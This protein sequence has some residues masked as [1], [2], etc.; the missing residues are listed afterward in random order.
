MLEC[1]DHVVAGRQG[2]FRVFRLAQQ[3]HQS[4]RVLTR[5]EPAVLF[6]KAAG[7]EI[8]D[9]RIPVDAAEIDI[10]CGGQRRVVVSFEPHQRHV[11]GAA[12]EVVHQHGLG[13][14]HGPFAGKKA[15]LDAVGDGGGGRL[16]DDV[17]DLQVGQPAGVLR[18]LAAGS[19][20]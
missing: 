1:D 18:G 8:R 9:P 13:L 12:A 10:A 3:P 4:G 17:E 16:V 2:P 19:L 6:R 20:K 5:I 11:E 7:D 15:P 14:L